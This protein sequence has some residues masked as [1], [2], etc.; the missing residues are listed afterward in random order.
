MKQEK[1]KDKLAIL[2]D[3]ENLKPD[4]ILPELISQLE[5]RFIVYP[6]KLIFNNVS[7]IKKSFLDQN[8]K[9]Y[10]LDL[11]GAYAPVGKNVADFRLYIE[12]L[13]ILY[14]SNDTNF[15]IVS[16]DADYGELVIKLHHENRYVI[17]IG[18][19]EKSKSE[20]M[21]LFDEF[22][23]IEDLKPTIEIKQTKESSK[24]EI[25]NKKIIKNKSFYTKLKTSIDEIIKKEKNKKTKIIYCSTIIKKLKESSLDYFSKAKISSLDFQKIGFK[26][27]TKEN[28]KPETSYIE[29]N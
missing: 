10:Q 19:K 4:E 22:I 29:I 6:R 18:P 24:K 25:K 15:C 20:Y 12:A 23:F 21:N 13:Q 8:I 26:I 28:N 16:G 2:F 9:P 14:T 7:Q 5:K 27:L 11:I 17:G 3:L 1:Q